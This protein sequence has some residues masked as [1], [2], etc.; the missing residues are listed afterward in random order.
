[1]KYLIENLTDLDSLSLEDMKIII[2]KLESNYIF[3]ISNEYKSNPINFYKYLGDKINELVSKKNY[4][5]GELKND[6]DYKL[7]VILK[8]Y[9]KVYKKLEIDYKDYYPNAFKK[10]Y[11]FWSLKDYQSPSLN[12]LKYSPI[13]K[14]NS[15]AN[16]D[17][18]QDLHDNDRQDLH[19]N[20][21]QEILEFFLVDHNAIKKYHQYEKK[22]IARGFINNERNEWKKPLIN[23]IRYIH[24]CAERKLL[25]SFY[26]GDDFIDAVKGMKVLYFYN[27]KLPSDYQKLK[28]AKDN[29]EKK[30]NK[31]DFL[32]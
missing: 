22:L 1:M 32:N 27:K 2:D 7:E 18:E 4:V 10:H 13:T 16:L 3:D 8:S 19:D 28:V 20:D 17:L 31:F 26:W 25:K 11:E 29:I 24:Y 23:F 6:K 15:I 21:R 12:N 14:F 5:N 9:S 30:P